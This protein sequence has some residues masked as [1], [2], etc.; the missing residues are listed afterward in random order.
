MKTKEIYLEKKSK[1][2]EVQQPFKK[3]ISIIE[4]AKFCFSDEINHV[5]GGSGVDPHSIFQNHRKK[6]Y[7]PL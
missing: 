1:Q 6:I 3:E 5:Q 4:D 7:L 2:K